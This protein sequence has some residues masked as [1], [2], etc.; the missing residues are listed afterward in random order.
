MLERPR[1]VG[2]IERTSHLNQNP[3]LDV[4][5]QLSPQVL[6]QA[7]PHAVAYHSIDSILFNPVENP[8]LLCY[9]VKN[10]WAFQFEHISGPVPVGIGS[11]DY[12]YTAQALLAVLP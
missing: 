12:D 7:S 2:I 10:T 1:E 4:R 9:T 6:T 8:D 3:V 5:A 11:V